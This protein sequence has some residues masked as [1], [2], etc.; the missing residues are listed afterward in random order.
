M[1]KSLKLKKA[2]SLFTVCLLTL[3]MFP[4]AVSAAQQQSDTTI[5]VVHTNDLHGY[6]KSTSK[7]QIGFD[8]LKALIDEQDPD[9]ILD[10]GD[11]FHGQAFA[12]VEQG[13]SMAQLLDAVGYDAMT[14]G[15]HDWSYGASRLKEIEDDCNF[16]ILASNV[17]NEDGSGYFDSPYLVKDVVADDGTELRVGVA[18]AIDDEFYNSTVPDNVKG[19]KFTEE[20]Q[21]ITKTAKVLREKENCD[22]VIA[23]THQ[24]DC[25]GFVANI[26]GVD[27]VLAGHE[28]KLISETYTDKDGKSVPLFE[29]NYYFYNVGIMSL[30]YDAENGVV[31]DI[32]ETFVSS[33]D[34]AG[35]SDEAIAEKISQIESEEQPILEEVI[36]HSDKEYVYSWEEI[37]VSEQEIGRI[38][39]A[40]YL[41]W[42]GADVAIENAGGIRAGI[43]KGDITY[44]DLI[45]ISPYG[46][47]LVVRQLT[48][49][50]ILDIV[51]FSLE[52][53]SECDEVYT[54][55]KE[56]VEAGEDPYQYSWP[57]NSGSV[58]QFGGI[59]V[60]Y[61][62]SKPEG[63]RIVNAEIGGEAVE[64][65]KLYTVAM[66][67]YVSANTEYPHMADAELVSE[68]GTCE[69]ALKLYIG[70]NTFAEAA[71]TPN[72]QPVSVE[73]PTDPT[74]P[75]DSQT[76]TDPTDT[77]T[78]TNAKPTDAAGGAASVTKPTTS[79]SNGSGKDAP[80]T[81]A[82]DAVFAIVIV[83]LLSCAAVY[84]LSLRGRKRKQNDK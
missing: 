84:G 23:I 38:V 8:G 5:R 49:S 37:R 3:S 34:T 17:Q 43:P 58:I 50:Q 70:K 51:E 11:T 28:H 25:E 71:E 32:S 36:G 56:A 4:Q 12:T 80:K 26:S 30:T 73:D 35:K 47:V 45:S 1:K 66:N 2:A 81:G 31:T 41:D 82:S 76:P 64:A 61:D 62:M 53:S 10:I 83:S 22:I 42:T 74:T 78:P 68:Y 59:K 33:D 60:E 77:S 75:T 27:A 69:Q 46:N 67:N 9:L 54:K 13:M 19:L 18:G 48:G 6:Y 79:A 40:A 72:L 65:D 44:G 20:A 39:T 14:P 63:S 15:N 29:A 55:Q 16:K 57:S 21:S 52:L 24:H 7:G